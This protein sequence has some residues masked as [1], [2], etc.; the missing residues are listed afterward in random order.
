MLLVHP[1]QEKP[2][3]VF[4]TL[5]GPEIAVATTKAYSTQLVAGYLLSVQFA[6]A[7]GQITDEQYRI[8]SGGN[9][10]SSREDPEDY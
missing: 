1:L 10:D 9:G 5:A 4:Y 7:R 8:L 6:K 3:N 2:I